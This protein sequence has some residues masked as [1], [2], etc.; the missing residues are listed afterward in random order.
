MLDLTA[1]A[2]SLLL[3]SD[4][5]TGSRDWKMWTSLGSTVCHLMGSLNHVK[6]QRSENFWSRSSPE[7]RETSGPHATAPL[8]AET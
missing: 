4:L 2:K 5:F 7:Q 1:F 3:L 8:E 6:D